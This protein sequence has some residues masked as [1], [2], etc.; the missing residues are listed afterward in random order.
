LRSPE[1]KPDPLERVFPK[2]F[3]VRI[4]IIRPAGTDAVDIPATNA[5]TRMV[6]HFGRAARGEEPLR[7]GRD[8][9]LGTA[10]VIDGAFAS[11]KGRQ[12]L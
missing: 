7:Y 10:R 5:Y 2:N 3:D 6:E 12:T 9:A 8:D 1:G 11:A 4:E